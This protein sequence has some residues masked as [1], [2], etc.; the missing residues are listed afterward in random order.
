MLDLQTEA[1]SNAHWHELLQLL[2]A[3]GEAAILQLHWQY[4]IAVKYKVNPMDS[5]AFPILLA[6][7]MFHPLIRL[8]PAWIFTQS[9]P[10]PLLTIILSHMTFAHEGLMIP[11]I[12]FL[13]G[14]RG[15]PSFFQ[16]LKS[17]LDPTLR[18]DANFCHDS[19]P[20]NNLLLK[21]LH[22]KL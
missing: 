18:D 20:D 21:V 14:P 5:T 1:G 12:P 6:S 19:K 17:W 4:I 10:I 2:T 22:F 16:Q 13:G 11:S 8:D 9:Y 3:A 15:P 7:W